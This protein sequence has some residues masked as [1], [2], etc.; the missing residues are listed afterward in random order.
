[1][2]GIEPSLLE[3]AVVDGATA[4]QRARYIILSLLRPVFA[5]ISITA[6]AG[7]LVVFELPLIMIGT[8]GGPAGRGWFFIPYISWVAFDRFRMG[9]ATAIGWLVFF[10]SI[11]VT[12]IQ[13][14]LFGYGEAK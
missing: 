14:R 7:S 4:W 12:I 8:T 2:S 13:L 9:Y 1:M 11:A 10:L 6:A 5:Y 3:A